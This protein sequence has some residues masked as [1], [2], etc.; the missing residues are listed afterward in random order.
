LT[1]RPDALALGGDGAL[2]ALESTALPEAAGLDV[3]RAALFMADCRGRGTARLAARARAQAA[4]FGFH[5]VHP[6]AGCAATVLRERGLA[7][8]GDLV[9]TLGLPE[10]RTSGSGALLWPVGAGALDGLL[11][12]GTFEARAPDVHRIECGGE[13]GPAVG[14]TDVGLYVAGQF[15]RGG[16]RGALLEFGGAAVD[17]MEDG[18]REALASAASL[19][20]PFGVLCAPGVAA[21]EYNALFEYDFSSLTPQCA[22]VEKEGSA[23]AVEPVANAKAAFVRRVVIGP[24]ASGAELLA[25]ARVLAGKSIHSDVQLWVSPASRGAHFEA[26]SRGYL[27]DLIDAGATVL[28]SCSLPWA[29]ELTSDDGAVAVTGLCGFEVCVE[30]GSVAYYVDAVSAAAAALAGEV[31]DPT[32]L[33]VKIDKA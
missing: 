14:G 13:L 24:A 4:V 18:E 15:G 22:V 23:L 11:E 19:C 17:A 2:T 20:G 28:P 21:S 1:L 32:A 3:N 30:R 8:P 7:D 5:L 6:S 29:E 10:G 12:R 31:C 33:W 16:A 26:L 27:M 25:A 9:A